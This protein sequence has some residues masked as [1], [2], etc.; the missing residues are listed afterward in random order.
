[1]TRNPTAS[2]PAAAA[3]AWFEREPIGLRD[4]VERLLGANGAPLLF[5]R[6]RGTYVQLSAGGAEL[7]DVFDGR[8]TAAEVTARLAALGH[9]TTAALAPRIRT[10][11]DEL[12]QADVLTIPPARPLPA[13]PRGGAAL[14]LRL[15]LTKRPPMLL[16]RLAAPMRAARG[17]LGLV[18]LP[19][20]VAAA[21]LVAANALAFAAGGVW[22][23]LLV[24]ALAIQLTVHELAHA[25]MC[26][27]YRVPIREAGVGLLFGVIPTAYVDRTDAYRLRRRWPRALIALAGPINDLLW[28][29][30]WAAVADVAAGG[31]GDTAH[32][33]ALIGALAVLSNLNPLLPT[34]G[35]HAIEAASGTLNF[36]GRALSLLAHRARRRPLPSH[37]RALSTRSQCGYLAFAVVAGTYSVMLVIGLILTVA[38]LLGVLG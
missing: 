20:L 13:R 16:E 30:A 3:D 19:L 24:G 11:L 12:R 32:L 18:V 9:T 2:A 36:R 17:S 35:Y 25:L 31:L 27:L 34:D 37:L 38:R 26:Q 14:L 8:R 21:A 28:A 22:V 15:P 23:P 10:F 4:D 33:L 7:L 1:M 6:E 5:H 29:G